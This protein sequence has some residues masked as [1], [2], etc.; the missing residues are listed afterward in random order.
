MNALHRYFMSRTFVMFDLALVIAV[1]TGL[2]IGW[3]W[4]LTI[5]PVMGSMA[6]I[7]LFALSILG[8]RSLYLRENM[9]VEQRRSEI[10]IAEQERLR[11][12]PPYSA[13]DIPQNFISH[14][15]VSHKSTSDRTLIDS[16]PLS[17]S[18]PQKKATSPDDFNVTVR[19]YLSQYPHA[20]IREVERA[21]GIPKSNIGRTPAWINRSR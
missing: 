20:S 19:Y 7:D 17:Q 15:T 2:I 9:T 10:R 3:Q 8:L 14:G 16:V 18:V 21:T 13:N 6:V 11:A 5:K 4:L 12:L 1:S